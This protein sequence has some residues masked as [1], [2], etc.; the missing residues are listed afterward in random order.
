MDLK[1]IFDYYELHYENEE[2]IYFKKESVKNV[3]TLVV[4]LVLTSSGVD[5]INLHPM[6]KKPQKVYTLPK[7]VSFCKQAEECMSALKRLY[8]K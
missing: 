4:V 7:V 5:V 3:G 1:V 6:R 2:P 8:E